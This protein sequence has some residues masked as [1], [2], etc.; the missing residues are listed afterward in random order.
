LV[1]GRIPLTL[2]GFPRDYS[3]CFWK[4]TALN[5]SQPSSW[6]CKQAFSRSLF[7]KTFVHI[8]FIFHPS[9]S[10]FLIFIFG[11]DFCGNSN[12][13]IMLL[14]LIIRGHTTARQIKNVFGDELKAHFPIS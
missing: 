7:T 13:L 1:R 11:T 5:I 4:F 6:S 3:A 9:T 10:Y 14:L 12:Y 8:P 2:S